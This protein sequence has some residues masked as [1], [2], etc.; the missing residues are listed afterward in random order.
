[1][2]GNTYIKHRLLGLITNANSIIF[3]NLAVTCTVVALLQGNPLLQIISDLIKG[4]S[5]LER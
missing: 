3:S 1:M 5:S 4:V 2:L